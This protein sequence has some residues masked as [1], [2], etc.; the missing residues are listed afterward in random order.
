MSAP[1]ELATSG[2]TLGPHGARDYLETVLPSEFVAI[3]SQEENNGWFSPDPGNYSVQLLPPVELLTTLVF[4]D[5]YV[6]CLAAFRNPG[7]KG[8]RWHGGMKRKRMDI[9]WME[10][11]GELGSPQFWVDRTIQ[12][13]RSLV[14]K[15]RLSS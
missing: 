12:V 2:W 6:N 8:N 11:D 4:I 1:W 3:G 14:M 7:A 13:C 9:A 10:D 5:I 15:V